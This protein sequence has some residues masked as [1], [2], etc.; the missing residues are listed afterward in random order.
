MKGFERIC[1]IIAAVRCLN[2]GQTFDE[3]ANSA[4]VHPSTIRRW[5]SG[6]GFYRRRH[7]DYRIR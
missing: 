6:A 5:V 7:S 4:K 3:I 2:A 1:A